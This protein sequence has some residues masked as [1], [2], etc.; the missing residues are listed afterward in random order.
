MIVE[1]LLRYNADV[2]A[3]DTDGCTPLHLVGY[4][5]QSLPASGHICEGKTRRHLHETKVKALE[6]LRNKLPLLA[7]KSHSLASAS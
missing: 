4:P 3:Q 1:E 2:A 5:S 7:H 6:S